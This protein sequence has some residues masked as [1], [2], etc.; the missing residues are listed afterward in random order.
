MESEIKCHK[1]T[2]QDQREWDQELEEEWAFA[3][4]LAV[5]D[6]QEAPEEVLAAAGGKDLSAALAK[7]LAGEGLELPLH[8][9]SGNRNQ[10]IQQNNQHH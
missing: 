2:E 1:A 10:F 8:N 4:D 9:R 6:S 3:L 5:Q 7:D